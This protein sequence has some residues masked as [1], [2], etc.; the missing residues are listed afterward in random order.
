MNNYYSLHHLSK[1][2]DKSLCGATIISAISRKKRL[3]ELNVE[4]GGGYQQLVFHTANPPALFLQ[5]GNND[6][7]VNAATFFEESYGK[8]IRFSKLDEND[9]MLQI[10]LDDGL[11]LQFIAFGPTANVFLIHGGRIVDQFRNVPQPVARQ[12]YQRGPV[13]VVETGNST[14][15]RILLRDPRFPRQLIGKL[16]D[17][18]RLDQLG[19]AELCMMVDSLADTMLTKPVYRRL[20]DNGICLLDDTHVPDENATIFNDVNA[21]VRACWV[22]REI[23]DRF[24]SRRSQLA[25]E[26]EANERRLVSIISGL[27]DDSKSAIRADQYETM[28]HILMA[29]SYLGIPN[30]DVVELDDIYNPGSTTQISIK[31]GLSYSEN[32]QLYYQKAKNSRKSISA[33]QERLLEAQHRLEQLQAL[34]SS[35]LAV[36][37]PRSLDR[38]LKSNEKAVSSL[39]PTHR[40]QSGAGR[41]WRVL[42]I[43]KYEVWVGKS[44][45]GNDELLQ[46]S[47]K[48]DLWLHAR[49]VSG[50]HVVVRMN[51]SPDLPP[52]DV[53][54]T[55]ASWA[56]WHSKAKTAGIVPVVYTKRKYVRKPKGAAPGTALVDKEQVCLIEPMKP[57]NSVSE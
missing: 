57:P 48:E 23:R 7:R 16:N 20:S 53:V 37:G 45:A 41:P 51:R 24:T 13:D 12:P 29:H 5:E 38:W 55:A 21:L 34:Q 11:E 33:N 39:L 35:Y 6:S 10:G 40:T 1:F 49:H 26:M 44:A 15:E 56:A 32:A 17:T 54:E 52:S 22:Q 25:A 31:S 2:L 4:S 47:H 36:D 28:G 19:T 46:A 30:S 42:H 14:K 3:L 18:L 8:K 50:S 27:E 43:G 9:R